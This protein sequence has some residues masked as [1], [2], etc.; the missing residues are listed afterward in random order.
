MANQ[1][2]QVQF[3]PSPQLTAASAILCKLQSIGHTAYFAGGCVRDALLQIPPKDYDIATS[4]TPDI[5]RKLFPKSRYVGESFGVVLV[6]QSR[7]P[8][9]VATFRLE[10]GYTDGRRPDNVQF[11]DAEH[12][13]ARRDFTINGLF[14]DIPNHEL[15]EHQPLT[16]NVID[17]VQGLTD[18]QSK[19]IRAIGDPQER[20][21]E[22]Y[23]RMLRAIRFAARLGFTIASP[24]A[25]AIR[26]HA[27]YLGQISRERIGGELQN[28]LTGSNPHDAIFLIHQLKLDGPILNNDHQSLLEHDPLPI[29][30]H[31]SNQRLD[32]EPNI[33]FAYPT[34]LAGWLLDRFFHKTSLVPSLPHITTFLCEHFR[35][36]GI[37]KA[38]SLSNETQTIL[39]GILNLLPQLNGWS[40]FTIAEQK[41]I[42]ASP[43]FPHTLPLTYAIA[44]N[45]AASIST[46]ADNLA[47][48]PA[49]I[50]PTPF[51]TG[52][53]LITL[54]LSPSPQFKKILDTAYDLQLD[55]SHT[56][57]D[58][59]LDWLRQNHTPP[60]PASSD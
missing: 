16:A 15:D 37:R 5:V 14:A 48:D 33:P 28:M 22:D 21:A 44:P 2:A 8:I 29:L 36:T 23:L 20:F 24:T 42:L 43:Y 54:G 57:R 49:G 41:R 32:S 52:E 3:P 34:F 59:A 60:P 51:L 4:A 56:S 26:N 30:T 10:W 50:S 40:S 11:T 47:N 18:L 46:D 17:F 19:T 1:H 9:E 45:L 13:A 39:V 27:K 38:L 31:L 7:I 53:D 6:Y 25:N 35:I 12:D 55:L 58:A